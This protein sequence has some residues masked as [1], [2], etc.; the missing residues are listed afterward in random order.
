MANSK[1]SQ[2]KFCAAID[3]GTTYT[4][5]GFAEWGTEKYIVSTWSLDG[6]QGV[7]LKAPTV[8]LFD[9]GR[10]FEAFGFDAVKK[11]SRKSDKQKQDC[12]YFERFKMELHHQEVS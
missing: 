7:E 4:G 9:A 3:F 12:Y 8:V 10:N 6:L 11:Y 1:L 5:L 2:P